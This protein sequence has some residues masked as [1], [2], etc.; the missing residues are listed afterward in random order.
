MRI[1]ERPR[2]QRTVRRFFRQILD[3]EDV[4]TRRE[5]MTRL[6]ARLAALD[7]LREHHML[8]L[9]LEELPEIDLDDELFHARMTVLAE[10]VG[11]HMDEA[12]GVV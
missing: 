9:I 3:A 11:R 7:A 12:A 6:V 5:A 8:Q 1:T 10:V 2:Q 4:E